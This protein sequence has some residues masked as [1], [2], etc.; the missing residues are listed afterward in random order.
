M[1]EWFIA[2]TTPTIA[3]ITYKTQ[4]TVHCARRT[5]LDHTAVVAS[6]VGFL[7]FVS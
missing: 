6:A 5:G 7:P 3:H 4:H 2:H 1:P